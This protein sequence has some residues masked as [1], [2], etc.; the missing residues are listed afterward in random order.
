MPATTLIT[1]TPLRSFGRRHFF[2]IEIKRGNVITYRT[3]GQSD[4]GIERS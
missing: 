1:I 2:A 4:Y 3:A